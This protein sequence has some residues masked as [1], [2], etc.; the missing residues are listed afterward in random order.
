MN[1]QSNIMKIKIPLTYLNNIIINIGIDAHQYHD[2]FKTVTTQTPYPV[3]H[4]GE[5]SLRTSMLVKPNAFTHPKSD[6]AKQVY[7]KHANRVL[8]PDR[9]WWDTAHVI[10]L[11]C[12]EPVIS[13]IF[14]VVKLKV[15]DNVREYAEKAFVLWLN[16]T[17]GMLIVLLSREETR[18]RWTRLKMGQWRLLKVLDVSALSL[19][20]LK[21]LAKIF[22]AYADK[23]LR[24]IP[25][26]F[27]PQNP[28]P[29][30]IAVDKSFVKVF[31]TSV[32][33]RILEDRL[34]EFYK[35]IYIS[36][37]QWIGEK[38]KSK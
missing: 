12:T 10:A 31:N 29:I 18:G 37:Q 24:R 9:I 7:K 38:K 8:V 15:P 1:I 2:N 6:K 28:D 26:Q 4:G 27:N 30:R 3:I 5:E 20:M 32:D 17:W 19:D 22:D 23:V 21:M 11:Y 34:K 25:E 33:N 36:L 14:Y 13:N 35:C 16:T